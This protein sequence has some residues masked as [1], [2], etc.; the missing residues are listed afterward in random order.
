MKDARHRRPAERD[1]VSTLQTRR[2]V[3]RSIDEPIGQDRPRQHGE[4]VDREVRQDDSRGDCAADLLQSRTRLQRPSKA[5]AVHS[6][7][8]QQRQP[9][10]RRDTGRGRH[11]V[12]QYDAK[13]ETPDEEL[14]RRFVLGQALDAVDVDGHGVIG[15]HVVQERGQGGVPQE[16]PGGQAYRGLPSVSTVRHLEDRRQA[17]TRAIAHSATARAPPCWR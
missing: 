1:R 4:L 2:H 8:A 7:D 6:E 5:G 16:K 17:D 15:A 13:P 3:G 14:A 10:H 11:S 9:T 12:R